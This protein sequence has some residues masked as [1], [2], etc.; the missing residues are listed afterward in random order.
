MRRRTRLLVGA[1]AALTMGLGAG[2]AFAYFTSSGSGSGSASVGN[3]KPVTVVA[4]TGTPSTPLYPGSSGDVIL[5]ISNPNSVAV[6]L[7]SVTGG[8]A[9]ITASGGIGICTTTGVT[10]NSQ[11]PGATLNP[12]TT[13]LDLSG[14]ASM[15]A[16]SQNGCQKATFNIPVTITVHEG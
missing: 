4:V 7:E 14:A 6:T 2:A 3:L 10:F 13:T 12:G 9:S 1:V 15:S 8:P 5:K 16:A 11:T